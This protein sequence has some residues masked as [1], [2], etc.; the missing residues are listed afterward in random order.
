MHKILPPKSVEGLCKSIIKSYT[1]IRKVLLLIHAYTLSLHF[2]I[3]C[4]NKLVI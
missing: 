2:V 1:H 3:I 4:Q